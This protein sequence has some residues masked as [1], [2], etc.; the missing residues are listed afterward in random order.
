MQ[1]LTATGMESNK[2]LDSMDQHKKQMTTVKDYCCSVA[3][4]AWQ[5]PI[6]FLHIRTSTRKPGD[7][8][9]GKQ[10]ARLTV[11]ASVKVINHQLG[12]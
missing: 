7:H 8:L 5:S 3:S 1:K 10:A 6:P 11:S 2:W 9:T 12:M 4:T